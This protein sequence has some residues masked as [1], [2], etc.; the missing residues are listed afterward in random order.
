MFII[1]IALGQG[2]VMLIGGL[3]LSVPGVI[4]MSAA[5]LALWTSVRGGSVIVGILIALVMAVLVGVVNGF[6]VARFQIPAF[7]ITLAMNG[8]LVGISIGITFGH[9]APAAPEVVTTLF[10]GSGKWF[11]IGIPVF[12]FVLVALVGYV[13]Q[14]KSRFGRGAYLFGSSN[15]A[16]RIAGL[17][18]ERIQIGIYALCAL[19][20]GIAG[21]MLLGLS[22]NAELQLGDEWAIP[23]ISAVLV[24]GTVIGSGR[25]YWQSTVAA[26]LLLTSITVVI[27]AT[28]FS[29]G[30][31]SVLYGVVV[32]IALLFTRPDTRF[33]LRRKGSP[34]LA[35]GESP[36]E[37]KGKV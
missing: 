36:T 14:A 8:I 37:M 2:L 19:G 16:A 24:G 13:I 29:Q 3:D 22:G 20:S 4:A 23:A 18:V 32:L 7:I 30:W 17:P 12:F 28:G 33:S 9:K 5:I 15:T 11:G 31:K 35:E 26:C 1:T 34:A 10:S 6:L 21:I 27:Q 25:G